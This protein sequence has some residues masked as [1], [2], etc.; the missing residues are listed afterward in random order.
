MKSSLVSIVI[1]TYNRAGDLERALK[2]VF[3]QT[4]SNW[5]V[6]II[7]NHSTDN[8]D[9]VVNNFKDSRVKLFK[10]HN[11]GMIAASRNL[12]IK[13]AEGEYIAFLDS[14]DWWTPR[15]LDESLKYLER[16]VDV[17]YHDLFTVTKTNQRFFWKKASTR[18]LKS[19]VFED[20]IVRG[21]ALNN[22][23]VVIR[24]NFLLEIGPFPEDTIMNP[25]CDYAAWLHVAKHTENFR[26]I[27]KTL[28]Y[29]WIGGG[30]V[31]TPERTITSLDHFESFYENDLKNLSQNALWF[32][33]AKGRAHYR[34]GS[35]EAAQKKLGLVLFQPVTFKL[36]AKSLYMI[37][38]GNVRLFFRSLK[39]KPYD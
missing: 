3:A 10:I 25:I 39:R 35:Y 32:H 1:P 36:K 30:N 27:P 16:G 28:G 17:I 34:L 18:G 24:K 12:G 31:T 6:L 21:N 26:R 20:L 2:S 23:S 33:Y 15:K 5:E 29:L 7:D 19:P 11:L 13:Y 37:L 4:Y 9:D 22:S 14:D 38:M 8:T